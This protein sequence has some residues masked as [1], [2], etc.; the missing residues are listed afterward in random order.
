MTR[1]RSRLEHDAGPC[2][3]PT[4]RQHEQHG[5]RFGRH[6]E[7]ISEVVS[8]L[9]PTH[10]EALLVGA[11]GDAER[12]AVHRHIDRCSPCRTMLAGAARAKAARAYGRSS[13]VPARSMDLRMPRSG[14]VLGARFT[15]RRPVGEGGAGVVWE[16]E[17]QASGRLVALKILRSLDAH[18]N[19]R[20]VRE[21]RVA[22]ALR[23]PNLVPILDAF[24]DDDS[25]RSV[26][27]MECLQGSSLA[28]RLVEA[29]G[30]LPWI[31]VGVVGIGIAAGLG[32]AHALGVVHR[33]LKPANV[34]VRH[35]AVAT[36]VRPADVVVL[37][38][39]IAKLTADAGVVANTGALTRSGT[40]LGTP[41]Y[42]APEQVRAGAAVEASA[43]VW[44]LG[45]LLYECTSGIRPV[46]GVTAV[47]VSRA[48]L[49]PRILPLGVRCPEAPEAFVA[50][51]GRMLDPV[52][53]ARPTMGT[54]ES[55]LRR[56]TA[57]VGP[58]RLW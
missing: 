21:V 46:E 16:A 1:E 35:D 44:A 8:C 22:T 52:A 4:L 27:A 41:H 11:L 47:D 31:D 58:E 40:L 19:R 6:P 39:G 7:R 33:D 48:L 28:D 53:S 10:V 14:D 3:L 2:L 15:L 50:L 26:L 17:E 25:G 45:V 29:R 32:A 57:L 43:D 5:L 36:P 24:V 54:V 56:E 23:H 38:F 34:F 49:Q 37:D 20:F 55:E 30:S 18:A 9:Q 42:M 51:V 13:P 12:A